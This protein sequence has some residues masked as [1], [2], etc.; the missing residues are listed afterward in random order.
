LAYV[1]RPYHNG[2]MRRLESNAIPLLAD[3][4]VDETRSVHD[5]AA[6]RAVQV[7]KGELKA[8]TRGGRPI[9]INK[10]VKVN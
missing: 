10:S 2:S 9:A 7:M 8:Q 4:E 3:G 6:W 5:W 1:V